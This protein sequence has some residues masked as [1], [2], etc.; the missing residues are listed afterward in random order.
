MDTRASLE[1]QGYIFRPGKVDDQGIFHFTDTTLA[2]A[3]HI[4][5]LARMGFVKV[6]GGIMEPPKDPS[7]VW[8]TLGALGLAVGIG[9]VVEWL[10]PKPP[11]AV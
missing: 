10:K 2:P 5:D 4:G 8:L 7:K 1:T 11:Q 6:K 3:T 9:F